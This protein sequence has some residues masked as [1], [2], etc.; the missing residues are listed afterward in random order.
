MIHRARTHVAMCVFLGIA[1]DIPFGNANAGETQSQGDTFIPCGGCQP[2]HRFKYPPPPAPIPQV[3][4]LKG[5]GPTQGKNPKNAG[6]DKRTGK[7]AGCQEGGQTNPIGTKVTLNGF[8]YTCTDKGWRL[9]LPGSNNDK[10]NGK[11][12]GC[13]GGGQMNPIGTKVTLSGYP[14]TCT[15]EGWILTLRE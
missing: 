6:G 14:Y 9:N 13:Q 15:D 7:S 2:I 5:V 8:S 12:A 11:S 4:P 3:Q 10:A 1:F